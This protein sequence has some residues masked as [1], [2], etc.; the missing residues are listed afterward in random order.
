MQDIDEE[1]AYTREHCLI[2]AIGRL[3]LTNVRERNKEGKWYGSGEAFYGPSW[4]PKD[5]EIFGVYQLFL[6]AE[7]LNKHEYT[8]VQIKLGGLSTSSLSSI[9]KFNI[10]N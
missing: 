5:K 9:L 2:E 4:T 8:I 1:M 6:I 10:Y 7:S 3:N